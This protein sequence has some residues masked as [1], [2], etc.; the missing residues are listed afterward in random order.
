LLILF[1]YGECNI[2]GNA[3]G[4]FF[5]SNAIF[6]SR[7]R[8]YAQK[9]FHFKKE[10]NSIGATVQKLFT[11]EDAFFAFIRVSMENVYFMRNAPATNSNGCQGVARLMTSSEC[12]EE[13][14]GAEGSVSACAHVDLVQHYKLEK[15]LSE[16][17][18]ITRTI[19][20]REIQD[21]HEMEW[22][23]LGRVLDRLFFFLTLTAFLVSSVGILLPAYLTHETEDAALALH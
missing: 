5:T 16:V 18:V 10:T 20:D 7:I 19:H 12:E 8:F 1:N 15:I 22:K 21:K 14:T 3:A 11:V 17:D 23:H 4:T 6:S 9:I 13:E 2:K